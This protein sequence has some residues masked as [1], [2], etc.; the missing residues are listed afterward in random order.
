MLV[1]LILTSVVGKAKTANAYYDHLLSLV[2]SVRKNLGEPELPFIASE[3]VW[4]SK[5]TKKVNNAIRALQ[6]GLELENC[7]YSS[8]PDMGVL[9]DGHLSA[10]SVVQVG[11]RMASTFIT[12]SRDMHE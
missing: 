11:D 7:Y 10:E 12:H 6:D 8:A 2:T 9:E 5:Q 3:I 1:S 4:K